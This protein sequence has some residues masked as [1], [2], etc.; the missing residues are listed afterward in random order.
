MDGT[1]RGGRIE[2]GSVFLRLEALANQVFDFDVVDADEARV[3]ASEAACKNVAW[4]NGKILVFESFQI[5][6]TNA[7]LGGDGGQFHAAGEPLLTQPVTERS[8]SL[9]LCHP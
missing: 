5:A 3:L 6:D 9:T 2:H 4:E 7:G 1:R 8:H